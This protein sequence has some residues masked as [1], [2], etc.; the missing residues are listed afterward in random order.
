MTRE[1]Q[2]SK[3]CKQLNQDAEQTLQELGPSSIN[4]HEQEEQ[5]KQMLDD[6]HGS[7]KICGIEYETSKL[8]KEVDPI[9]FRVGMSDYFANGDYEEVF[10]ELYN[11]D[12]LDEFIEELKEQ[13][14]D[15][16]DEQE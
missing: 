8:L 11:V 2:I 5:Y 10:C 7:V 6:C 15:L 1:E 14:N 4:N 12:E 16:E 9:A 3:L 13:V